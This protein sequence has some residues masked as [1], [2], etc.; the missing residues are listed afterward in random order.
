MTAGSADEAREV[1]RVLLEDG[2]AAC[3]NIID[4]MRSLYWWQDELQED[5][6][7]VMIAK[8]R[9][10][11]VDRLAA[12]VAEIHSYE[13]PCVVALP[14]LGGHQPFIDWIGAETAD[15]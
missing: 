9:A 7:T 1:G 2:L 13:C 15:A 3:V 10:D 6:E 4:G 5:A 8:T 11:L 14:I 12:K